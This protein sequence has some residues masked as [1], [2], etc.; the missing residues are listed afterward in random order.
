MELRSKDVKRIADLENQIQGQQI[1]IEILVEFAKSVAYADGKDLF[2]YQQFHSPSADSSKKLL[3]LV[4]EIHKFGQRTFNKD[5]MRRRFNFFQL[6][7]ELLC[8]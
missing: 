5:R 7:K 6:I 2:S 3:M 1:V 8:L 4:Q